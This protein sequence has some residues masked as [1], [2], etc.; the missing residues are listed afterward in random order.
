MADEKYVP[1]SVFVAAVKMLLIQNFE[2]G[3]GSSTPLG[4]SSP[5]G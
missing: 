5:A 3:I 2:L 4:R 1:I